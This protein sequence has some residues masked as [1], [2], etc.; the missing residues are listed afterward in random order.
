VLGRD[1][2]VRQ[3]DQSRWMVVESLANYGVD[4]WAFGAD[5][6]MLARGEMVLTGPALRR[7]HSVSV[8]R[9]L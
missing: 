4:A 3:S 8:W 5:G 6:F 1:F 9:S 7:S 2:A